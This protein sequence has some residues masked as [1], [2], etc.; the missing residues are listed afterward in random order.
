MIVGTLIFG[1]ITVLRGLPLCWDVIILMALG[2]IKFQG[3]PE[4]ETM[5]KSHISW[6]EMDIQ[7]KHQL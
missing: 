2:S 5:P 1:D 6:P 4:V 7:R 3:E